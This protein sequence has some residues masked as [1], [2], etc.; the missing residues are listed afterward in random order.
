MEIGSHLMVYILF[1]NGRSFFVNQCSSFRNNSET[2]G[3]RNRLRGKVRNRWTG[4]LR[5]FLRVNVAMRNREPSC[6]INLRNH[7]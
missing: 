1:D 4:R 7:T 2:R 3:R 6:V 5:I